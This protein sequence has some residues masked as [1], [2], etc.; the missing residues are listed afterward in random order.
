MLNAKTLLISFG[1]IILLTVL[2]YSTLTA[3]YLSTKM[4]YDEKS[5]LHIE[6]EWEGSYESSAGN[7]CVKMKTIKKISDS[8]YDVL[9]YFSSPLNLKVIRAKVF[10]K[11]V[12]FDY[13]LISF[14]NDSEDVSLTGKVRAGKAIVVS[15]SI[16]NIKINRA[17]LEKFAKVC[18]PSQEVEIS[19]FEENESIIFLEAKLNLS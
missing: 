13:G 14:I 1:I 16:N 12:D 10:M 8:Q 2:L 9:L 15:G 7:G 4:G 6:G 17:E 18:L 11:Y 5:A 3:D 19:A